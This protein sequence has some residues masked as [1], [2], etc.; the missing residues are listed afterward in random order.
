VLSYY[1]SVS[2]S[3]YERMESRVKRTTHTLTHTVP[4]SIGVILGVVVYIFLLNRLRGTD[5]LEDITRVFL[6]SGVWFICV[7]VPLILFRIA[8][9]FYIKYLER[10]STEYKDAQK[11]RTDAEEHDHWQIRKDEKFWKVLD[12]NSVEK[13]VLSI[14]SHMGYEIKSGIIN[15]DGT[16]DYI[17][18]SIEN[19]ACLRCVINKKVEHAD[20]MD[21]LI[22]HSKEYGCK[23]AVLVSI[24]GFGAEVV[25][26]VKDKPIELMGI[27]ELVGYVESF[28]K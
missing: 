22:S 11:Y 8:G 15:K 21:D 18:G 26:Y 6:F 23:R 9:S 7:G 20:E 10:Y 24:Q 27:R 28:S 4:L 5:L 1:N 13:E 2:G 25:G 16:T 3:P 17:L 14:F 19:G 12:G